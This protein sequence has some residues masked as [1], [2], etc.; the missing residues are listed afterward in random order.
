MT[1]LRRALSGIAEEAPAANLADLIDLTLAGHRRKRR[2][3]AM[4]SAIATIATVVATGAVTAAVS[5]SRPHQAAAPG[6]A[7]AAPGPTEA[8]PGPTEATPEPAEAVPDLPEG[9]VG[10]LDHAYETP[11]KV[12]KKRRNVDCGAVEWRVVT[13]AGRTYRLPQALAM[14]A[15]D[16]RAPIAISRDGRML[17]YYSR[18][19]QAHVVRDL[20]SGSQV[21]SPVTLKEAR[22][23]AGSMLVLSDDG[24]HVVFDPREGSKEPGLLIDVRTGKTVRVPGKYEAISVRNGVA[25]LVRYLKTDL[26]LMPVT[27][28]GK[29]VRF[30]GAFMG[31]S[32]LAPDGRTVVAFERRDPK[33]WVQEMRTLTLLDAGTGRKLRTVPIRG[34]PESEPVV[35]TGLWRSGSELT[36]LTLGKRARA[37]GVDIRTGKAHHLADYPNTMSLVLPGIAS[38]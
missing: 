6:P 11:C 8:A 31:F 14:T 15:Q 17:A 36:V 10:P 2:A 21:T 29:P 35:V 7:E 27:G 34:L 5:P 38:N 9:V 32:E 28:G 3:T 25:E 4:L 16:R 30:N 20:V 24:R 23:G 33:K 12:D 18:Q 22:I 19:A 37:Y 13:R 1:R 26:W